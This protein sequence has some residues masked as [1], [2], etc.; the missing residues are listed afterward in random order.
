MIT[1]SSFRFPLVVLGFLAFFMV[2]PSHGQGFHT[3]PAGSVE[4]KAI[5]DQ[6]RIPC[7]KDL[8]QKV[9]FQVSL[10]KVSGIWAAARVTPLQPNGS[11]I[12]YRN[13]R[14]KEDLEQGAFDSGG[15][16]LLRKTAG[17]W[18]LLKWRFGATDTELFDWIKTYGAPP[19]I[20]EME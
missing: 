15:E 7:E 11:P 4:R 1:V 19:I 16:A 12:N 6:L 9:I 5:L 3:P 13:T 18:K 8:K 10:L 17:E 20:A 2:A 14:Y